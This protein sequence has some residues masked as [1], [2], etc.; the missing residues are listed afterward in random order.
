MNSKPFTPRRLDAVAETLAGALFDAEIPL[1]VV[2]ATGRLGREV[3]DRM[4]ALEAARPAQE[5]GR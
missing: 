3:R 1:R 5:A 2:L 4:V